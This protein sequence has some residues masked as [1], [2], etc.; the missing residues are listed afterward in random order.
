MV[1]ISRALLI[2]SGFSGS[3]AGR[4]VTSLNPPP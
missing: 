1:A 4:P 3:S 2:G